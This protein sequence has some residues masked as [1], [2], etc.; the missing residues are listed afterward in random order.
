MIRVA[1]KKEPRFNQRF[2]KEHHKTLVSKQP[3][4]GCLALLREILLLQPCSM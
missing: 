1:V 3:T 4:C 2:P